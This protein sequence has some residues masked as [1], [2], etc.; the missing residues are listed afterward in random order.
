MQPIRN[1]ENE[2]INTE[3]N[4]PDMVLLNLSSE[5]TIQSSTLEEAK[6]VIKKLNLNLLK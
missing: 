3:Q 2:R 6:P 1:K 4:E 5:K